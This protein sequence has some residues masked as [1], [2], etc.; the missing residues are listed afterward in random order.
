MDSG[1]AEGSTEAVNQNL[2][3]KERK[4]LTTETNKQMP[5]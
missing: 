3:D 1:A 5:L 4:K 2:C